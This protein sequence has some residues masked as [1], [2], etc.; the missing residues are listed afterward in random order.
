LTGGCVYN[1]Q[2]YTQGQLWDDGCKYSCECLDDATGRYICT[3]KYGD[4]VCL[5][6][7]FLEQ[8]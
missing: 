4:F 2:L 3:E 7:V 1:G 8:N 6:K 5:L